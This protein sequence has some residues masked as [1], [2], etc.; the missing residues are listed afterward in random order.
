MT[1][2]PDLEQ[3]NNSF[4]LL[5]QLKQ[6]MEE[7]ITQERFQLEKILED[8]YENV[9]EPRYSYLPSFQSFFSIQSELGKPVKVG[10]IYP[11]AFF[12]NL[13]SANPRDYIIAIINSYHTMGE[14]FTTE[15]KKKF[16][17]YVDD[18][19]LY[20]FIDDEKKYIPDGKK[21]DYIVS[22]KIIYFV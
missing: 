19:G 21:Y 8:K 16:K 1:E 5:R 11:N 13:A 12:S 3:N 18:V 6:A 15:E 7:E 17:T 10:K 14:Q 20:Q 2:G 9:P 22:P 4:I